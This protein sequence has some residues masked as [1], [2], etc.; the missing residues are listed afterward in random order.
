MKSPLTDDLV[1]D[2]LAGFFV[3]NLE[4]MK[5]R[6]TKMWTFW[7]WGGGAVFTPK[8]SINKYLLLLKVLSTVSFTTYM[9]FYINIHPR[10]DPSPSYPREKRGSSCRN[11]SMIFTRFRHRYP[12]SMRLYLE[13]YVLKYKITYTRI[14]R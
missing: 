11:F 1:P 13:F 9:R 10:V 2:I 12:F 5:E 7:E 14:I 4:G 3:G 8:T 6:R